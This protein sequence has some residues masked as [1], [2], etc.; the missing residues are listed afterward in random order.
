MKHIKTCLASRPEAPILMRLK[1][2]SSLRLQDLNSLDIGTFVTRK[3]SFLDDRIRE[4]L[5]E[6]IAQRANGTHILE[7]RDE[8]LKSRQ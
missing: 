7:S 2:Y 8:F 1:N 6:N 3:L 5:T 4:H